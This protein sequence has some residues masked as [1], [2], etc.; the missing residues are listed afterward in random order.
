M[1]IRLETLCQCEMHASCKFM[2][3]YRGQRWGMGLWERGAC[4]RTSKKGIRAD[5]CNLEGDCEQ[6]KNLQPRWVQ[7]VCVLCLAWA[8]MSACNLLRSVSDISTRSY[9]SISQHICK[10][11]TRAVFRSSLAYVNIPEICNENVSLMMTVVRVRQ[12]VKP[13][14]AVFVLLCITPPPPQCQ[15]KVSP[16][17]TCH[18]ST[19][20]SNKYISITVIHLS[21]QGRVVHSGVRLSVGSSSILKLLKSQVWQTGFPCRACQLLSA[22]MFSSCWW[23]ARAHTAL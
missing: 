10:F 15:S 23:S 9:E 2:G 22:V 4:P 3:T 14:P 19:T 17:L 18:H 13:W 20:V 21:C 16:Q 6:S 1:E 8:L 5:N 12:V 7:W 11:K